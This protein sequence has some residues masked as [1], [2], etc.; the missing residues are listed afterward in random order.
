VA[1]LGKKYYFNM[2]D[3]VN[4]SF[5]PAEPVSLPSIPSAATDVFLTH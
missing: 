5:C 1:P 2:I 3:K 4:S